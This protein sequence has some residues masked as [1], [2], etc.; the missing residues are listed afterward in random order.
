VKASCAETVADS[1]PQKRK[2]LPVKLGEERRKVRDGQRV[3]W[4]AEA[5]APEGARER[6]GFTSMLLSLLSTGGLLELT[7]F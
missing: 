7:N 6:G 3:A 5:A 2:P 4:E 1:A